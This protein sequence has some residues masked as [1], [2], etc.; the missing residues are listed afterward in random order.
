MDGRTDGQT[1]V[2]RKTIVIEMV[3][4]LVNHQHNPQQQ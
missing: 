1:D 4:R 3:R 2:D